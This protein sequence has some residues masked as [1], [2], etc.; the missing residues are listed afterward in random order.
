MAD[1]NYSWSDVRGVRSYSLPGPTNLGWWAAGA[2]AVSILLHVVV[3]LSLDNIKI[4][5]GLERPQDLTTGA[6][7]VRQVEI[8]PMDYAEELVPRDIEVEPN[9]L[10]AL[11][12]EID[13][14]E[15]L[16]PDQEIDIRPDA[17]EPEYA[18]QLANPAV[19]GELDA[20]ALELNA[21]LEVLTDLPELGRSDEIFPPA[22]IGQVTVDPGSVQAEDLDLDRFTD[23]LVKKGAGGELETGALEGVTTL[24][25]LI[26]LPADVL[27]GKRTLLPSDLL[28][29]FNSA[30]LRESAKIGLMKLGLLIDLNPSLHCWIE[31][32]TD[33]L[34]GDEF[35]LDL[36]RRRAAAVKAYLV[37][38]M[39]MEPEKIHSRGF[40]RTQPLVSEGDADVQAPNRRVEIRMR[41]TPPAADEPSTVSQRPTNPPPA[42]VEP[43]PPRAVLVRPNRT[44]APDEVAEPPRAIPVPEEPVIPRAEPVRED[45]LEPPPPRAV[46]VEE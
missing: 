31:G 24:D 3:F 44:P 10:S 9:E 1:S 46:P 13:I 37:E 19:E 42:E 20:T 36:S 21:S 16:P 27:V 45:L 30:E 11:L 7:N 5:L 40:G 12:E 6:V 15:Q 38:S 18:L 2:M 22:A 14:F 28:F 26:G 17:L 29:E 39:R 33:R 25:D 23:D 34:G 35:N 43:E 8:P 4:A 41:N 32:H